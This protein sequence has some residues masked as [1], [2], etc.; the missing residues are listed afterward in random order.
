M[1]RLVEQLAA[2]A[3][4]D[5]EAASKALSVVG[6][7]ARPLLTEAAR[8]D[9]PEV[10][11]RV[12]KILSQLESGSQLRQSL[13]LAALK[14]L[15]ARG[16]AGAAPAILATLASPC[17]NHTGGL[18]TEALWASAAPVHL[19]LFAGA[20]DHE[21]QRVRAAAIVAL[22]A[23]AGADAVARITP[24]LDDREAVIRLA[25]ARALID[26]KP[27]RAVEV[28]VALAGENDGEPAWQADALLQ[29]KTGHKLALD[30]AGTIGG[31]WKKWFEKEFAAA[32]LDTRLGAKRHDLGAG[33]GVLVETFAR[34]ADTLAAGYGRFLYEADND[35]PARV[36]DGQLRLDGD[37][38]EG[39][40]RLAITSQRMI[41][42]DRWPDRLE[43]RVKLGGEEGNNFGWHLGVSVGRV[44][45]LFHP[46]MARG[47]FRAET[48]DGHDYILPNED[49]SF[50][51]ANGVMHEMI[52][53]V[54]RTATGADFDVI[55]N[56]GKGG[57]PHRKEFQVTPEQ[58]GDF[59][60]IGLERSGRTG[61]D[62]VFD[63]I[64][65]RLEP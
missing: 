25:A 57:K 6:E 17:D 54:K 58:L 19:D 40:Q 20:L 65:I 26:R 39:D 28:L 41:G 46:G 53:K 32:K 33:R 47:Y 16:D 36:A 51:P 50:V 38:P 59:D 52:I 5:R 21:D 45:T 55:V 11:A 8:S 4:A 37:N 13:L 62:A 24:L 60:R 30:G 2:P 22:E 9:D 64:S 27:K 56:D 3:F 43:V 29:M 48:T 15:R 1:A 61:A 12:R 63:S 10:Q 31:G 34:G 49:M 44:K 42:R 35:G 23:A 18:A 14:I 7:A